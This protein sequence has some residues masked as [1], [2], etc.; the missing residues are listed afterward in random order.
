[1]PEPVEG[2]PSSQEGALERRLP[3]SLAEAS[4]AF[5]A[6]DP[7]REALGDSLHQALLDSQAAEVRFAAALSDEQLVAAYRHWPLVNTT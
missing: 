1:L 4:E 3:T 6:S 5:A 2:D 7:L